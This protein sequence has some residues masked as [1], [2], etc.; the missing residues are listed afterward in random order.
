MPNTNLTVDMKFL[1]PS[2]NDENEWPMT[3]LNEKHGRLLLT[4]ENGEFQ[5]FYLRGI[6]LQSKY[7]IG[8]LRRPRIRLSTVSNEMYENTNFINFDNVNV[9]SSKKATIWLMNETE[10]DTKWK[11]NYVKVN[12]KKVY[13][14]KTMTIDEKEDREKV[15]EP[16]VFDFNITEVNRL[17]I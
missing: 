8:V 4:F 6:I 5:D 1:N 12:L 11:I 13:G 9:E 10:V 17:L 15:D 16:D 3:L 7:V 2:V 14:H